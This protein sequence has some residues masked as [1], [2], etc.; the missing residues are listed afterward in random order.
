MQPDTTQSYYGV[1]LRTA[2]PTPWPSHGAAWTTGITS[3]SSARRRIPPRLPT[4]RIEVEAQ[5]AIVLADEDVERGKVGGSPTPGN[6]TAETALAGWGG[7]IR[8]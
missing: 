7:R 1:S 4:L 5:G 6:H 8:T 2:E 3:A